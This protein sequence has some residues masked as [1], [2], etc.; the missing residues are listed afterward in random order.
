VAEKANGDILL[1]TESALQHVQGDEEF[2]REI[3][4]IFLDEIP[5]RRENFE[6]ALGKNEMQAVVGYAHSLK[7]VAL[8]I[9]AG[10]CHKTALEL[11]MAAREGDE[12]KVQE[13]Y[14]QLEDILGQ[15]ESKLSDMFS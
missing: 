4:Q 5:G 7:G 6:Q 10:T 12:L 3:Y 14:R 11:E 13:M 15:L 9:G 8:T 1:D 2:L